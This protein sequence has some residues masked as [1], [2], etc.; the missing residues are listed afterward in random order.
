MPIRHG[1]NCAINATSWSRVT[2]GLTSTPC[3]FHPHH[4]E[5]ILGKIDSA[6][7]NG[8]GLPLLLALMKARLSI[9]AL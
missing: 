7:D 2:L 5:H 3:Q 1:G 6:G 4:M 9:M 8:H